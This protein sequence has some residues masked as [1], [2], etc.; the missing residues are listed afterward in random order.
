M[1]LGSGPDGRCR[2]LLDYSVSPPI[3]FKAYIECYGIEAGGTA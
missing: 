1:E 3:G 2:A